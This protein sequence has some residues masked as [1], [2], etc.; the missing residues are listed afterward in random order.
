MKDNR[1][2]TNGELSDRG[3]VILAEFRNFLVEPKVT[4]GPKFIAR[5][6]T[7]TDDDIDALDAAVTFATY[8]RDSA[9]I[10]RAVPQPAR[11][12]QPGIP[13]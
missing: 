13:S 4:G 8:I 3:L 5:L 9:R 10:V 6:D 2:P 1:R 7:L 11:T 12:G